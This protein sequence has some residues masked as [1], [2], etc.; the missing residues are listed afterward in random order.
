MAK[1]RVSDKIYLLASLGKNFGDTNNL[2]AQFGINLGFG[3]GNE[4]V[5]TLEK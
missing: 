4:K 2:I 1:Y 3:T 5:F